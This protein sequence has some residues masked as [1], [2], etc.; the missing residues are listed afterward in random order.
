MGVWSVPTIAL[1]ALITW[2]V[3]LWME[4][5]HLKDRN[6]MPLGVRDAALVGL[7]CALIGGLLSSLGFAHI[8]DADA[9]QTLAVLY[10]TAIMATGFY[11]AYA[12]WKNH[13]TNGL[14]IRERVRPRLFGAH[15]TKKNLIASN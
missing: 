9:S 1:V 8:I 4:R 11:A 6:A 13:H 14:S 3:V 10:R 7:L 15:R 2:V 12:S 5:D